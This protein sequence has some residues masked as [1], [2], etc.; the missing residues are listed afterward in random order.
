[1]AVYRVNKNRGYTVM[2]NYH[3]RDKTL[4]LKAVGLLSKMLS[5]NDGWQF[6]TKGLSAICKEGPDAVLAALRELEDAGYLV[7]HQ[8]RDE[9]GRMSSMV[10]EIYEKPQTGLPDTEKPHTEKPDTDNPFTGKPCT[11]NPAQLNTNQVITNERN[12][13][14]RNYQSINLDGMDRMDER[15]QYRELIR[16]NRTCSPHSISAKEVEEKVFRAIHDQIELVV[17]LEKALE[18]IERLPS[19]NRKAFNYEAQIAKLE[20][21]IERYQKLKL[22]LYEDLSDGIIDK[23]EYFEFRN[24]Y[25]KIIEEKQEALLRVKKEMKQSI[26]TGATE[27]NWVTLFKQYENI[28]ELNRRVLMALVDRILIYEDHAI[29]IVFKYKD[30]YQQTLEYVLG[31]ADELAVAG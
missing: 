13:S 30:E 15:E 9:K 26:A 4:S 7:R 5:F 2:A 11:E 14:L 17:N 20:E 21:E 31:Y 29:E 12:N 10:F 19:Q 25:T 27:R 8:S 1:M 3:L 23:S 18:M 28:E 24:S 16:D 6:S 22:R